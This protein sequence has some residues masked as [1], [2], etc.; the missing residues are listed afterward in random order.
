[1]RL[2]A[3]AQELEFVPKVRSARLGWSPSLNRVVTVE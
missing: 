2:A 3:Y 1:L